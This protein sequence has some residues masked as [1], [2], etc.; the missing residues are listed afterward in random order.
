MA[1]YNLAN[2]FVSIEPSLPQIE[3][4]ATAETVRPGTGLL[5]PR[6]AARTEQ[7]FLGD[8]QLGR[9]RRRIECG[10][11]RQGYALRVDGV[12]QFHISADGGRIRP[13]EVRVP[14]SSVDLAETVLGPAVTLALALQDVWCLHA[15]AIASGGAVTAFVGESGAGKST[16]ARELPRLDPSLCCGADDVLPVAIEDGAAW[17][18]PRFPQLKY[19]FD[20]QPG[21]ALPDRLPLTRIFVL[22]PPRPVETEP[23]EG[24]V[25]VERLDGYAAAL[26]LVR[27]TVAAKLFTE[28]LL[29]RHVEA[30]AKLA[31][32]VEIARLCYPRR[33]D[34]LSRVGETIFAPGSKS[35]S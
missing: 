18:L 10:W 32:R 3:T 17:A 34:A 33:L 2:R 30:C 29:R 31:E 1:T 16:L 35:G 5:P 15:S 23:A 14:R 7:V 28:D 19:R 20:R 24:A 8:G 27:H 9:H 4:L 6:P 21:E 11:S 12:G 26:A 22:S 13:R 25:V